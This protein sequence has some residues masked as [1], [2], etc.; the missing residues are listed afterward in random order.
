[1]GFDAFGGRVHSERFGQRDN[2]ADDRAIAV[3]ARCR[4]LDEA[5]VDL[6][7]VERRLLQIAERTVAGS[8]IVQGKADAKRFQAGESH[9]GLIAIG[10]EHTL[11]N[12]KLEPLGAHIPIP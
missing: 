1:M 7:L 6:D 8:E 9:V 10:Q 3:H 5:L 11:G 4:A 2:G 12:L